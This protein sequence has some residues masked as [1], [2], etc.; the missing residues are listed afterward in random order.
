MNVP[1]LAKNKGMLFVFDRLDIHPFWMK[2]TLIPL[3]IIWLDHDLQVVDIQSAEPCTTT[4]CKSY[5]PVALSQYVLEI[6]S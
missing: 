3:D 1:F 4:I 5:F 2:D 6:N